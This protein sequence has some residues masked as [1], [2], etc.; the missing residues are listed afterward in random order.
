MDDGS[1]SLASLAIPLDGFRFMVTRVAGFSTFNQ[2]VPVI[3]APLG[4]C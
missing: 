2:F 3:S 1:C 4:A